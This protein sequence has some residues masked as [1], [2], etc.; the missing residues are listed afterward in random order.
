MHVTILLIGIALT[1]V[2]DIIIDIISL[3]RTNDINKELD[4]ATMLQEAVAEWLCEQGATNVCKNLS[5]TD[6]NT[7]HIADKAW[8]DSLKLV[9]QNALLRRYRLRILASTIS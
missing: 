4:G 3:G 8:I 1:V 2:T 7:R 5:A 9:H 6:Q